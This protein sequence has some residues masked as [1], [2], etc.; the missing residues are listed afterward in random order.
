[1]T[2]KELNLQEKVYGDVPESFQHRVQ[3]ALRRTQEEEKPMKRFTLRT[4]IITLVLVAVVGVALAAI[5]SITAERFGQ[6]Y[7]EAYKNA[8][9]Q[10]DIDAD[11]RT[12]QVGDLIYQLDDVIVTGITLDNEK[13]N[14][15]EDSMSVSDV[16]CSRIYATGTIRPAEGAKVVLMM[17]DDYQTSDPWNY[18]PYHNGG[19]DT[20]PEGAISVKDKAAETNA[21]IISPRV[22]ANGLVGSNGELLPADCGGDL[23]VQEDGSMVFYMEIDLVDPIPRQDEYTL[24]VYLANHQVTPDGEHLMDTRVSE[25]WVFTIAPTKAETN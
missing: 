20:I 16:V 1:M 6:Q 17:G 14:L 18:S 25:D 9:L 21:T 3:Y 23:I 12:H 4:V 24:S 19:R 2:L 7:G 8:M 11:L 10:S 13:D 15:G 5:S 22:V